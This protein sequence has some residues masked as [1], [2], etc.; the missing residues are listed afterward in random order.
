MNDYLEQENY[1][2]TDDGF[3]VAV[4]IEADPF[5]RTPWEDSDCHG[6]V[7][8]GYG[9]KR[10]GEVI[11]SEDRGYKRFYDFQGA[12]AK[13]RKD[14]WGCKRPTA[15][16]GEQAHYAALEDMQYLRRWL[17]EEWRYCVVVVELLAMP[18]G[19]DPHEDEPADYTPADFSCLGGVEYDVYDENQ[20]EYLSEIVA[21]LTTELLAQYRPA[22]AA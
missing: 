15:T 2:V 12:V 9:D 17:N 11:L 18:G 21:E 3:L 5:A 1:T 8:S 16:K 19:Y 13:A 14:G 7:R 6:P 4:K 22:K 10:P 20:G